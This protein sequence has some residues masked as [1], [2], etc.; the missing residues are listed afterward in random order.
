MTLFESPPNVDDI[1]DAAPI[2]ARVWP[3]LHPTAL[4]GVAGT[5][6]NLIQP[7]TEADPAAVLVSLLAA[8]GA[9]IGPEPHLW[10]ANSRHP[11]ILCPLLVGR[12]SSGAKGTATGVVTRL[13]E[14]AC[15]EF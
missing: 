5:I 6:V 3:V 8:A 11:A 10:V 1:N 14:A 9:V 13:I 12:T 15:P 7:T 2:V 4:Q